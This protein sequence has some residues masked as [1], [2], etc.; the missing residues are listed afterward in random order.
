LWEGLFDSDFGKDAWTASFFDL[1]SLGDVRPTWGIA[2]PLRSER[3]RR[4]ALVEIDALAAIMLGLTADQLAL[5]YR[6]QFPVLRKYEYAMLFDSNGRKICG[7]HQSAGVRQGKDDYKTVKAWVE[8][9]E[10]G[11]EPD[12]ELPELYL[13]PFVR[14]DREA[15]MRASHAEFTQRLTARE[16]GG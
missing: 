15:E 5:M 12:V 16:R 6:A 9:T 8:A 4:A 7:Y 11:V 14:P 2:T 10:D 13:P 1:P 3:G